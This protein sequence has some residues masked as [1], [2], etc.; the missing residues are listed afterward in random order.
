VRD[1]DDVAALP[2]ARAARLQARTASAIV[3][4][5]VRE[6]ADLVYGGTSG[7][8][9]PAR[10]AAGRLGCPYAL[11][12]EDL[13]GAV[14]E[15]RGEGAVANALARR[16][17]Q[18]VL[19]GAAFLTAG[20][21]GIAAAYAAQLDRPVAA[22][23]NV[24]PRPAEA[25]EDEAPSSRAPLRLFW[26]SQTVGPGRGLEDVVAAA[27]L[28]DADLLLTIQGRPAPGYREVLEEERRRCD[29]RIEL[30]WIEPGHPVSLVA[31]TREH[32][33]ALCLEP[34]EPRNKDLAASNKL[35]LG[36]AAGVALILTSTRGQRAIAA[37]VGPQARLYEPG[38]AQALAAHLRELATDRSALAE[39]KRASFEA[40]RR[41]WHWE[42]EL[43]RGRVLDLV[44]GALGGG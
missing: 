37:D 24:Y 23:H 10:L 44:D 13:Y 16:V 39:A 42:H 11:D 22:I 8:M 34:C 30:A 6:P 7:G 35:F 43:E 18:D 9:L 31:T 19:P 5:A 12:L 38:D 41:R 20:S 1:A 33:V 27:A 36:L 15:E 40:A 17:E 14:A 25:P 29:A 32:D 28:A 26:S 3:R 21:P 2:F 4:R